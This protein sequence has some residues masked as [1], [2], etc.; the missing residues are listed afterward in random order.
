MGGVGCE[1]GVMVGGG[2]GGGRGVKIHHTNGV[3]L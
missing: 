1:G 3:R 2:G